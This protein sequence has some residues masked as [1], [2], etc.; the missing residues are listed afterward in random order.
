MVS[1]MSGH[2]A[3][4]IHGSALILNRLVVKVHSLV[5]FICICLW[6]HGFKLRLVNPL[7][8]LKIFR[9]DSLQP[10][11]AYDNQ[12]QGKYECWCQ[13]HQWFGL[14]T[15]LPFISCIA[16]DISEKLKVDKFK[17]GCID[18]WRTPSSLI[19]FKQVSDF[20]LHFMFTGSLVCHLFRYMQCKPDVH[21]QAEA[22]FSCRRTLTTNCWPLTVLVVVLYRDVCQ[23]F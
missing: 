20:V 16:Q 18:I 22:I 6:P 14:Q 1:L 11:K 13:S 21:H 4:T 9:T 19:L 3:L 15:C 7:I 10:S 17:L 2:L 23:Q 5:A 8:P 12:E